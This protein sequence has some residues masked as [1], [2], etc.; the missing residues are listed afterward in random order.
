VTDHKTDSP[1]QDAIARIVNRAFDWRKT[2]K[3]LIAA[4]GARAIAATSAHKRASRKLSEAVDIAAQK[5][6]D[7]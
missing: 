2:Q 1:L 7:A 6:G 3:D 4:D 5:G